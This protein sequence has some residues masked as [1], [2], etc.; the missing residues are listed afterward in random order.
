VFSRPRL[1]RLAVSSPGCAVGVA[2]RGRRQQRSRLVSLLEAYGYELLVWEEPGEEP[3]ATGRRFG[4]I[5]EALR[6]SPVGEWRLYRHQL[7]TIEALRRGENVVLT[8]RT[9]SGKTEAWAL[10]ALAEG[11]RV[12]AV[13]PTL[14]LA[15]DQIR[16]LE[17]YYQLAGYGRGAVVRVD[18]PSLEK[19]GRR[20][21]EA[22]AAV[23]G[24][25]VVVTNPAF[26]LAE[27]K[28]LAVNPN[29]ALLEDFLA[30]VDLVVFDELDFYGPRGAH[31]LLSMV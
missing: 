13:Y 29:R 15:A 7:E 5:V 28:R 1:R 23:A 17:E 18:R 11:W 6:G 19:R 30:R 22:A 9:G 20:G 24:A 21:E 16:R 3:E 14:A 25:R 10:A 4:D 26:L 27:M 2:G 8:A 31:L 12:L